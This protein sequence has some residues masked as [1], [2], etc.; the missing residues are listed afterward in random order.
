MWA[1][2]GTGLWLVELGCGPPIVENPFRRVD[3]PPLG[4]APPGGFS[5]A[6]A[7]AGFPAVAHRS[8]TPGVVTSPLTSTHVIDSE[9]P[10]WP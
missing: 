9:P 10:L 1:L 6:A 7:P 8:V 2:S 5:R 4:R 3:H